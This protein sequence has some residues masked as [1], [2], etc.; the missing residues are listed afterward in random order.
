MMR[1]APFTSVFMSAL[2]L[3]V[4]VALVTAQREDSA[5]HN[6]AGHAEVRS[7]RSAAGATATEVVFVDQID[8][9]H[10]SNR[11]TIVSARLANPRSAELPAPLRS[12]VVSGK[13]A[14]G[15]ETSFNDGL[16]NQPR[17]LQQQVGGSEFLHAD[18]AL[19]Q[20]RFYPGKALYQLAPPAVNLVDNISGTAAP[21]EPKISLFEVE[22]EAGLGYFALHFGCKPH[23]DARARVVRISLRLPV[24]RRNVSVGF[25]IDARCPSR[26]DAESRE[27]LR[28]AHVN[29]ANELELFPSAPE[30][31]TQSR[32]ISQTDIEELLRAD[33]TMLVVPPQVAST[34]L[35]VVHL[36]ADGVQEFTNPEL[37]SSNQATIRARLLSDAGSV[38]THA[39]TGSLAVLYECVVR[40]SSAIIF[41]SVD[42]PPLRKLEARWVKNCGA[43]PPRWLA[44]GTTSFEIPDVVDGGVVLDDFLP[45]LTSVQGS[46][47]LLPQA[48]DSARS[49]ASVVP[50]LG[51]VIDETST[52]VDFFVSN[53]DSA[54]SL[55]VKSITA[56]ASNRSMLFVDVI[57]PSF[58]FLFYLART[59][60]EL[61]RLSSKRLRL[62]L[63]CI[64]QGMTPVTVRL[65]VAD[66]A[67]VTFS[68]YKE[69]KQ[70]VSKRSQ[71]SASFVLD[72]FRTLAFNVPLIATAFGILL[73][74]AMALRKAILARKSRNPAASVDRDFSY[75]ATIAAPRGL[76][77]ANAKTYQKR[78]V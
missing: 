58:Q 38:V 7:P 68:F 17:Q 19:F 24:L 14:P 2:T 50:G 27:S 73:T 6:L 57:V 60:E 28:L 1:R 32:A 26:S 18:R 42:V 63:V 4:I 45:P 67:P 9:A 59:D 43:L 51:F 74:A 72:L 49:S 56:E 21:A 52:W 54:E 25:A 11:F 69:C 76:A 39:Q 66:H 30:P 31:I 78:F 55:V 71:H 44:I 23:D 47:N 22:E 64:E 36:S 3:S 65:L 10:F 20:V 33:D 48:N 34:R 75:T 16:Q 70:P 41:L 8:A 40:N 46:K 13:A 35:G 5:A 62:R 37:H 53:R 15:F 61:A 29:A 12:V 77:L